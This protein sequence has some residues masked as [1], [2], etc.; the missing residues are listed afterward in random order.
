M[1]LL[2]SRVATFYDVAM[3]DVQNEQGRDHASEYPVILDE[4]SDEELAAAQ[5]LFRAAP[6]LSET[7]SGSKHRAWKREVVRGIL[8]SIASAEQF[9]RITQAVAVANKG[10]GPAPALAMTELIAPAIA[11]LL[12]AFPANEQAPAQA[13]A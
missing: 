6:A 13:A 11:R 10:L 5:E 4:V 7:E 8:E 1:Y 3:S 2:Y 9:A 12:V